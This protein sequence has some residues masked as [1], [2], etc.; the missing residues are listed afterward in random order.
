MCSEMEAVDC[1]AMVERDYQFSVEDV[2]VG[3]PDL[4]VREEPVGVVREVEG[5]E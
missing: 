1:T 4:V 2:V 3:E 5:A